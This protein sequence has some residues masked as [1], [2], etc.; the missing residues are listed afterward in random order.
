MISVG[1]IIPFYN[2]NQYLCRLL[3]S[4][5][6]SADSIKIKIFIVDNSQF[7]ERVDESMVSGPDVVIVDG[8]IGVGYGKACNIG[9]SMCKQWKVDVAVVVNQD[10]FFK[11]GSLELMVQLLMREDSFSV[12]APLLTRYESEDVESFFTHVYLTPMEDLVSDLFRGTKRLFYPIH[13]LC[14]ACFA[15]KTKDYQNFDYLFDDLFH[16]YYEDADLYE[17]LTNMKRKLM[18]VPD[19]VFHHKHT[20]TSKASQTIGFIATQRTSRHL[21][22]IKNRKASTSRALLA[23]CILEF[24]TIV[25]YFLKF[26]IRLLVAELQA[27]IRTLAKLPRL[28]ARRRAQAVGRS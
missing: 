7:G 5:A 13:Q 9:Y 26:E 24:R 25:E 21:F 18:F 17:R 27:C 16:M 15:I 6:V 20:N 10:G 28:L 22:Y 23:W 1:V 14:G 2:G 12:A 3:N 11:Q 4:I 8:G 19:A